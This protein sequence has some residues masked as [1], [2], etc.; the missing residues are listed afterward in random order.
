LAYPTTLTLNGS[1]SIN[2]YYTYKYVRSDGTPYYIGKGKGNRAYDSHKRSNGAEIRPK[3]RSQIIIVKNNLSE[4]QAWDLEK[5][6][7]LKYGRQDIGT[8]ILLNLKE[9]GEQGSGFRWSEQDKL[10]MS[11]ERTGRKLGPNSVSSPLIGV[12]RP[13]EVKTKISEANKKRYDAG[14]SQDH[15][16]KLSE[17]AKKRKKQAWTGKKRPTKTCPHCGKVG[18]DWLMSRWHFDNCKSLGHVLDMRSVNTNLNN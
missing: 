16:A 14:F 17:A 7:I 10:K 8:G 18:A 11:E 4:Q 3:D 12:S 5:E 2:I 9:G 13:D 6:L 1:I 15:K